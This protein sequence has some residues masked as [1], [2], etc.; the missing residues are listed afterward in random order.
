LRILHK[1]ITDPAEKI[2]KSLVKGGKLIEK[3]QVKR[4]LVEEITG[5]FFSLQRRKYIFERRKCEK[6]R[7]R[8]RGGRGWPGWCIFKMDRIRMDRIILG[9][10][11]RLWIRTKVINRIQSASN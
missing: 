6:I 2:R 1:R 10:R 11:I 3:K 7:V 8:M 9:S 4:E 5:I